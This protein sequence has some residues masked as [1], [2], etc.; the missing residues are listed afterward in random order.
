M[1]LKEFAK[2]LVMEMAIEAGRGFLNEH[3]RDVTPEMLYSAIMKGQDLWSSMPSRVKHKGIK[4]AKRFRGVFK[5][6]YD[7]ITEEVILEWLKE[8]RPELFSVIINTDGGI[9]WLKGQIENIKQGL[10]AE[11]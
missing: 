5:K 9:E 11:I 7:S 10:I 6:F 1:K 3:I 8:D 4:V 2:N